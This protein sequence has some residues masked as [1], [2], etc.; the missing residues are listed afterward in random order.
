[1]TVA[2]AAT[3][4]RRT[5]EISQK[6][7]VQRL[8]NVLYYF[9]TLQNNTTTITVTMMMMMIIVSVIQSIT[10]IFSFY[11]GG[12][13]KPTLHMAASLFIYFLLFLIRY[14]FLTQDWILIN[15]K[16]LS[17]AN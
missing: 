5:S 1:M 10:T 14:R 4:K 7:R 12:L 13:I 9:P 15:D 2:K 17:G 11:S 6:S 8:E 16:C 3:N